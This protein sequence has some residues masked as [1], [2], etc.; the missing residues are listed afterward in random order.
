ARLQTMPKPSRTSKW[1]TTGQATTPASMTANIKR[2]SKRQ[3][4]LTVRNR[5]KPQRPA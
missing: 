3:H 2:S 4:P 5:L 1:H